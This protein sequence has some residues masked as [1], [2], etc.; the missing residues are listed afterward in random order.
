MS[1]SSIVYNNQFEWM[2]VRDNMYK[3]I[4]NSLIKCIIDDNNEYIQMGI[5]GLTDKQRTFLMEI[6]EQELFKITLDEEWAENTTFNIIYGIQG[7]I[8]GFIKNDKWIYIFK[9]L[10]PKDLADILF[11]NIKWQ[12]DDDYHMPCLLEDVPKYKCDKCEAV[13]EYL[14]NFNL[15][16]KCNFINN[17]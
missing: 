11:D 7:F 1:I 2:H 14:V 10:E 16:D 15:C 17:K 13:V 6:L 3:V 4:N 9:S 12:L 8:Q 5:I